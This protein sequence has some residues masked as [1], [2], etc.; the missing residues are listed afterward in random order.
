MTQKKLKIG[1]IGVG[2][3]AQTVHLPIYKKMAHAE[4]VAIADVDETR[5]TWVGK[6]YEIDKVYFNHTDLLAQPDVD[7]VAVCAPTYLHHELVMDALAAGK[8]VLCEKPMAL[9]VA[10]CQEM[11]DAAEKAGKLLMIG[12]NQRYR[13]DVQLLK[14]HLETG[15][16]GKIYYAK[17]GW[18]LGQ[19]RWGAPGLIPRRAQS[20]SGTLFDLGLQ[21]LDLLLWLIDFPEP[22]ATTMSTFSIANSQIG[23]VNPLQ[24]PGGVVDS[25]SDFAA[26]F[27]RTKDQTTLVLEV[28]WSLTSETDFTYVSLNGTSGMAALNPLRSAQDRIF[29]TDDG[30]QLKNT[31]PHLLKDKNVYQKSYQTELTHFV[32][33]VLKNHTPISPG[34]QLLPS[35]KILDQ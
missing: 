13:P 25:D 12:M 14:A 10:H 16:F 5:A 3:I 11:V 24:T 4:V 26:L 19:N 22:E 21:I 17:A 32:D 29:L 33:C 8:H 30:G 9:T 15:E 7:A 34:H 2:R 6:R 31:T 18:L 27:V 23:N 1:I 20:R 28:S 35:M